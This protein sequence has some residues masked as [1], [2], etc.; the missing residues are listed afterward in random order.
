MSI[1]V[2]LVLLLKAREGLARTAR[3]PSP[4]TGHAFVV[5][6][7]MEAA[8]RCVHHFDLIRRHEKSRDGVSGASVDFRQLY[9]RTTAKLDVNRAPEPSDII[10]EN[11][12]YSKRQG[13]VRIIKTSLFMLG[14]ACFSTVRARAPWGTALVVGGNHLIFLLLKS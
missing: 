8:S 6:R 7:D 5:F 9:Y 11:L 1:E 10:W 14:I 3:L 4:C 12:P 2:H 13:R